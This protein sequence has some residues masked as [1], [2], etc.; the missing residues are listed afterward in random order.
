[1]LLLNM[2]KYSLNTYTIRTLG[3]GGFGKVN[4]TT[5]IPTQRW[6]AIKTMKK[7][8]ILEK[9]GLE[10]LVRIICVFKLKNIYLYIYIYI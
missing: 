10:M 7:L 4:A 6:F 3:K 5:F 1:M 9:K 8:T 2:I